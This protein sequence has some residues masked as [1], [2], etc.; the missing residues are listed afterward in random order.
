VADR[1]QLSARIWRQKLAVNAFS[2]AHGAAHV[3]QFLRAA[4]LRRDGIGDQFRRGKEQ[5]KTRQAGGRAGMVQ[6]AGRQAGATVKDR[7]MVCL[8]AVI[9]LTELTHGKNFHGACNKEW[10][11]PGRLGGL[12]VDLVRT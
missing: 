12:D 4:P 6:D 5:G 2:V 1:T 11:W 3:D 7:R 8:Q 9:L 10:A